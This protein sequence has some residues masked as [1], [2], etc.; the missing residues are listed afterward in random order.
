MIDNLLRRPHTAAEVTADIVRAVTVLSLIAVAIW[1]G[2]VEFA[3]FLLALGGVL[4][5]RMLHA[6][7]LL[8]TVYGLAILTAAWSSVAGL[9]ESIAW[10]DL[11]VHCVVTAALAP[12]TYL[13]LL[14]LRWLQPPQQIEGRRSGLGIALLILVLGTTLSVLWE[15]G[16]WVGHTY[17]DQN[18]QV[19]YEDTLGDIAAGG[20]GSLISGGLLGFN[21]PRHPVAFQLTG[22]S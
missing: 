13:L 1:W 14:S 4:I 17:I 6:S 19:G 3:V 21:R 2:P 8:D 11:V 15:Y 20:A 16:E 5:P 18:I 7:P 22:A 10:W 9:Y 12:V